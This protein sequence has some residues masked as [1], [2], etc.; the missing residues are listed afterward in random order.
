MNE[1]WIPLG[2]FYSDKPLEGKDRKEIIEKAKKRV[3]NFVWRK[4]RAHGEIR[5]PFLQNPE[6]SSF[7]KAQRVQKIIP[8][9]IKGAGY[10]L[11]KDNGFVIIVRKDLA[12]TR[13]RTVIAHELGHTFFFTEDGKPIH[14]YVSSTANRPND[15]L[16]SNIEGPAFEIGRQILVP[17]QLL[18]R[19]KFAS[20]VSIKNFE[21]LKRQFIVSTDVMARRLIHDLN[22]WNDVYFFITSYDGDE[23]KLPKN[24]VRFVG[25]S[26]KN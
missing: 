4:M 8:S 6:M 2:N 18:S 19:N 1:L 14:P 20:D 5:P 26:F 9:E 21:K 22:I 13:R 25:I 11:P 24:S 7:V 12:E 15:T 17:E 10:L 3:F 16:W 23:I